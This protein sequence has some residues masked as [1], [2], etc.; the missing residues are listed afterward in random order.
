MIKT[1]CDSVN[2]S[3]FPK[4]DH[5]PDWAWRD[6]NVTKGDRVEYQLFVCLYSMYMVC[7]C[8]SVWMS[9]CECVGERVWACVSVWMSMSVCEWMCEWVSG[10]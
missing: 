9:E 8:V 7:M 10:W 2:H 6:K 3:R 4:E 1:V 5:L